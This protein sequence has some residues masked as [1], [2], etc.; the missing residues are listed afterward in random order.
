MTVHACYSVHVLPRFVVRTERP[1][2]TNVIKN[3]CSPTRVSRPRRSQAVCGVTDKVSQDPAVFETRNRHDLA[4]TFYFCLYF[5]SSSPSPRECIVCVS[6]L[7]ARIMLSGK[8][9]TPHSRLWLL[10]FIFDSMFCFLLLSLKRLFHIKRCHWS[11]TQQNKNNS[12]VLI[13][14]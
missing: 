13:C 12:H 14:V 10:V 5:L 11:I 7:W 4:F 8:N 1:Y 2:V 6:V 9:R 3:K